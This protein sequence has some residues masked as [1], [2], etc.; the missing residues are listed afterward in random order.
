MHCPYSLT[1]RRDVARG[2]HGEDGFWELMDA[3]DEREEGSFVVSGVIRSC[4]LQRSWEHA[5]L[6]NDCI[7][8]DEAVTDE[9]GRFLFATSKVMLMEK[10]SWTKRVVFWFPD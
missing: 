2:K 8:L 1:Q 5:R 7:C 9:E 6:L 4:A 3:R 10:D